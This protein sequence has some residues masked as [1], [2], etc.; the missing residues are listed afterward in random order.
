M[1]DLTTISREIVERPYDTHGPFSW[2][3]LTTVS[4]IHDWLC[5]AWL[6]K[7]FLEWTTCFVRQKSSMRLSVQGH[8]FPSCLTK[9]FFRC[10]FDSP[11]LCFRRH[12]LHG[13]FPFLESSWK[14]AEKHQRTASFHS[15]FGAKCDAFYGVVGV[16]CLTCGLAYLDR[17]AH[18][19]N[20]GLALILQIP[21]GVGCWVRGIGRVGAFS[22]HA[23]FLSFSEA[24]M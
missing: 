14:S 17:R 15:G 13:W 1:E 2:L 7:V 21:A 24:A 16:F 12:A 4:L 6:P 3:Y 10:D 9:S 18:G 19:M 8:P 5:I 22:F 11:S 20:H 23:L